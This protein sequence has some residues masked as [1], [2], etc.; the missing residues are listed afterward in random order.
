MLNFQLK[1]YACNRKLSRKWKKIRI[2]NRKTIFWSTT[3]L[4]FSS[5][6]VC[7]NYF[8]QT[9]AFI[10]FLTSSFHWKHRFVQEWY[11]VCVQ[12][13]APRKRIFTETKG[14]FA[15]RRKKKNL[16]F[17]NVLQSIKLHTYITYISFL[18]TFEI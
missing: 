1:N 2:N 11:I 15:T 9:V 10:K 7:C 8:P 12:H 6:I 3:Y 5:Q 16:I 14:T 17:Y 13:C 4:S 18:C